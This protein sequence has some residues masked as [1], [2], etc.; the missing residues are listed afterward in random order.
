MKKPGPVCAERGCRGMDVEFHQTDK[1]GNEE[2]GDDGDQDARKQRHEPGAPNRSDP[3][4]QIKAAALG[5]PQVVAS[6]REGTPR[7]STKVSD[8]TGSDFRGSSI[9]V[10]Y[11]P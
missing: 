1:R 7:T 3:V 2:H 10:S 11:Y 4:Q 9:G 5:P 8:S 6:A